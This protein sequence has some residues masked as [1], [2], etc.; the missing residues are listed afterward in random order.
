MVAILAFASVMQSQIAIPPANS[1][2]SE[3]EIDDFVL[4]IRKTHLSEDIFDALWLVRTT[5][6]LQPL[7]REKGLSLVFEIATRRVN[8]G[9]KIGR[10][11]YWLV[12][13]L[14]D[15]PKDKAMPPPTIPGIWEGPPEM[16]RWPLFVELDVPMLLGQT[17]GWEGYQ[18]VETVKEYAL[19]ITPSFEWRKIPLS[20]VKDPFMVFQKLAPTDVFFK[21]SRDRRSGD[22]EGDL[23][24]Q[25]ARLVRNVYTPQFHTSNTSGMQLMS[26]FR[27]QYRL[28]GAVWDSKF[29]TYMLPN[30]IGR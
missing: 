22:L 5:N 16:P 26:L 17:Q 2:M 18:K 21:I 10:D 11:M 6:K 3:Q 25:L 20:P 8:A 9:D 13:L 7:G 19:R 28:L 15:L 14:H 24:K 29:Q 12:S 4:D 27:N 1:F 30:K 23:A